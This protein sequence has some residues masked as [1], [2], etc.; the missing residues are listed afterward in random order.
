MKEVKLLCIY[1]SSQTATVEQE[2]QTSAYLHSNSF[3][4]QFPCFLFRGVLWNSSD[5]FSEFA[6]PEFKSLTNPGTGP[7]VSAQAIFFFSLKSIASCLK[8]D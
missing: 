6:A 7:A 4:C 8:K 2:I 3:F 1:C 5:E